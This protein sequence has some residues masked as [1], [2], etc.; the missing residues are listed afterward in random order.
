VKRAVA[1]LFL[2]CAGCRFSLH[3]LDN[4]AGSD[5]SDL[6][7]LDSAEDLGLGDPGDLAAADLSS[8]VHD[9]TIDP[10]GNPPSL[11]SGNLAAQCVIGNPPTIDGNLSDWPLAQFVSL[12]KTTA[13]QA[14]GTWGSASVPDDTNSS[15]RLFVKWDLGYLYVAVSVTDDVRNTPNVPPS[16]TDNDAVEIFVDGQHQRTASYGADDWQLVYSA[17]GQKAA[18]QVNVVTWPA[19]THEAWGGTSPG[20]TVEAAIPWSILGGTPAALG[21]VVGFDIKLNDN[22][23]GTARDRDLILYYNATSSSGGCTA[24]YCRTDSFGAVQLQ[25]R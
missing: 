17:D 14:N 8:V 2:L 9:L 10:C 24:P 3:A 1:A 11:G 6:A 12:T 4:V 5:P 22:D 25:G 15:A 20:Y 19:G 18:G 16:L 7:T 21:R 13:A 23:V